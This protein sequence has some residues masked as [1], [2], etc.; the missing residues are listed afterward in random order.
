MIERSADLLISILGS[1]FWT[2]LKTLFTKGIDM[3]KRRKNKQTSLSPEN[4]P[5]SVSEVASADTGQEFPCEN[6]QMAQAGRSDT[7]PTVDTISEATAPEA[8]GSVSEVES[9]TLVETTP[10]IASATSNIVSDT[11][12]ENVV[13]TDLEKEP[14]LDPEPEV[15]ATLGRNQCPRCKHVSGEKAV[16]LGPPTRVAARGVWNGVEYA[17]VETRRIMCE[18]CK[19]IHFIKRYL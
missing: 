9:E 8:A 4:A 6:P 18:K 17:V 14:A 5:E 1:A 19:Q 3:T 12:P 7:S 16:K 10:N 15:E 13:E 11:E 2:A